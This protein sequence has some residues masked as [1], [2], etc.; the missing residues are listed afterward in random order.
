[1]SNSLENWEVEIDFRV[2][3]RGRVGA[4][5]LVSAVVR[6]FFSH[7]CLI[8]VVKFKTFRR[9]QN[10]SR[11]NKVG[12]SSNSALMSVSH[13]SS[14]SEDQSILASLRPISS[15]LSTRRRLQCTFTMFLTVTQAR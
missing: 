2:T 4:D 3:G 11:K 1:M 8:V 6:S 10:S 14:S 7:N 12:K 9:V 15:M 13:F 5:G